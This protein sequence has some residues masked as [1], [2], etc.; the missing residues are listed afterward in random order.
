MNLAVTYQFKN[1]IS[2]SAFNMYFISII[3]EPDNIVAN[4]DYNNFLRETNHKDLSDEFI[5]MRINLDSNYE[6]LKEYNEAKK[7]KNQ[8]IN[9]NDFCFIEK[10]QA[11]PFCNNQIESKKDFYE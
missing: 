11:N 10:L 2:I 1:P 4:V 8:E 6:Y 5:S 3:L 7:E 9:K